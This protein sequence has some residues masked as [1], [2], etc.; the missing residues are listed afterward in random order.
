LSGV[1]RIVCRDLLQLFILQEMLTRQVATLRL[2]FAPGGKRLETTEKGGI[3]AAHFEP[4]PGPVG[5]DP[6]E[7]RIT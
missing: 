1:G 3:A 7:P 6:I 2:A 4:L 5:V